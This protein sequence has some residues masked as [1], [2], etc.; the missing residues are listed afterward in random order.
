MNISK[1]NFKFVPYLDYS[2]EWT[3]EQLFDKY[4]CSEEEREMIQS[5]MRPLE[6]ILHKDTGSEKQSLYSENDAD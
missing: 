2:R 1:G 5:I 6:Y 4:G 3:D